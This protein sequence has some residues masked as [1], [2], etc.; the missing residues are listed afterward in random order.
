MRS[1]LLAAALTALAVTASLLIGV[2]SA[3]AALVAC[4]GAPASDP[5]IGQGAGLYNE[6]RVF[7]EAQSWWPDR[8][9]HAHFGGCVP[10]DQTVTGA[11]AVNWQVQLHEMPGYLQKIEQEVATDSCAD[12]GKADT[13]TAPNSTAY[14]N[15]VGTSNV[16][17]IA[18][19]FNPAASSN[20]SS[21]QQVQT[22]L[23]V[24]NTDG[25]IVRPSLRFMV[26]VQN[27][28]KADTYSRADNSTYGWDTQTAYTYARFGPF[29]DYTPNIPSYSAKSGVFH[30]TTTHNT[31]TDGVSR[32]ITAWEVT[33]DPDLHASPPSEGLVLG[34]G[35]TSCT[36]YVYGTCTG[37]V[38]APWDLDT[39]QL[40]NGVHYLTIMTRNASDATHEST[41]V[42]KLA[43]VVS[44]P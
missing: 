12:C 42:M 24:K 17:W 18:S 13:W 36:P 10:A 33:I 5:G 38:N 4:V 43:F 25:T 9:R 7:I 41:G 15:P 37:P 22:R 20:K 3:Q 44:N 21:W 11:V 16:W 34:Q 2:G 31:T 32:N 8:T 19:T 29:G 23:F 27:G 6:P 35:T 1:K 28:K 39:T 40:A 14:A 30:F 26:N